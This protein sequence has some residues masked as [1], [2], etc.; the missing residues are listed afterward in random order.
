MEIVPEVSTEPNY[1]TALEA[2]K[3]AIG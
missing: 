1:T 3:K 2:L